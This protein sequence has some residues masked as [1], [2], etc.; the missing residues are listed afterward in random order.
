MAL[1]ACFA[2]V[3]F[4]VGG[5]GLVVVGV[6]EVSEDGVEGFS[7]VGE[8]DVGAVSLAIAS[9]A[10]CQE[11]DGDK[12]GEKGSDAR[13]FQELGDFGGDGEGG[14]IRVAAEE[15]G[16]AERAERLVVAAEDVLDSVLSAAFCC[17]YL[18]AA[19]GV[20]LVLAVGANDFEFCGDVEFTLIG[21]FDARLGSLALV[22]DGTC[23]TVWCG[24][25]H[26]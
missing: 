23:G 20:V 2:P 17:S 3:F 8:S 15:L 12:V 10:I 16:V 19:L 6:D 9:T 13:L 26:S 14:G 5:G 25:V 7:F 11:H 4:E 18:W 24:G 22:M 21:G 1:F